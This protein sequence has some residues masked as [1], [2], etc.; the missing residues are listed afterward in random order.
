MEIPEFKH[1]FKQ[2]VVNYFLLGISFDESKIS[3]RF[4]LFLIS[5][6]LMLTGE[7]SFFVSKISSEN[8]LKLTE[9]A[10]CI[11]IG[12]L[13]FLKIVCIVWK[14][15]KINKFVISLSD[16]YS[17]ITADIKKQNIVKSELGFLSLLIKY[18]FI[19]NVF[20]IFVYNFSSIIIMLY[21]YITKNEITFILPYA[22]LL[23]FSTDSML[24]W[25]VV[26][27][28]SITNGFNCVLFFTSVDI[29]YYVLTCHLCC[30][31]SLISNELQYLDTMTMSSLRNIV[32]KHQYIL[33]LSLILEDIFTV[34]NFFNV[35]MG[36]LQIC[37]L[38]FN[39][40][41]GD[42]TQ[43]LGVVLFLNSVLIQIYMTCLF[44]EN[45]ICES[46]KVGEAAYAC[47]WYNM[48]VRPM[49]HILLLLLRSKKPQILTA[50]K[51]SV[52]SYQCFTKIISTSW[53]YFT[54]L[55][56]IY[57]DK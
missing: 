20:L 18:Y 17:E 41:M 35:L 10:P 19:L 23:P 46:E 22:V 40:T 54:I 21:Y 12:L 30:H 8:F 49:K 44:G 43:M 37:A 39:L 5:I 24:A 32:K 48:D 53:S 13:S 42:W 7:I 2:I 16:L 25:I 9:L 57:A 26:Y 45:L 14:R 34:P 56:T 36:S 51:F 1:F 3:I 15:E 55:R 47:L 33:K 28:F 31:F 4:Y 11:C 6:I 50:Y 38:G 27:I 52:I 29:L